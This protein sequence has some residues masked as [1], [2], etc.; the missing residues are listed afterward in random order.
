MVLARLNNH[1]D[2]ALA[3]ARKSAEWLEK[4]HAGNRDKS[5][6]SAI[7]NTYLNVADQHVL[8]QRFDDALQLC[9]QASDLARSFDSQSYLG[10]FLWVSAEAFR[11]QGDLDQAFKEIRQSVRVLE[12]RAGNTDQIQVM[13]LILAL[14]KEGRILGEDRRISLGRSEEAA[15]ILERAFG[16]ADSLVHQDPNDQVSRGRLAL[17]GL[18][19]ANILRHSDA[20]RSLAIYDHTLRHMAEIRDNSSFR[21]FEV[22]A[23]AGSTYSLRN[24]SRSAEARQRLDKLIAALV[25]D[26]TPEEIRAGRAVRAVE[27]AATPEARALLREWAAGAAGMRLTDDAA[28]ALGR[29]EKAGRPP[30]G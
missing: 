22:S 23:L 18:G 3:L 6:A 12:P 15:G 24:L 9:R 16:M 17:A 11:R 27:L 21:R 26:P 28:A 13:N 14:I 19:L 20:R 1:D 5:E 4:F 2:E 10:N 25:R 8:G 29:L 30:G 7:L